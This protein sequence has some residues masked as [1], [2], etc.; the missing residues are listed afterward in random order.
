MVPDAN[1]DGMTWGV[2]PYTG[3][4]ISFAP[5][6]DLNVIIIQVGFMRS[7]PTDANIDGIRIQL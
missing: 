6:F 7:E 5:I 2:E 1:V 4:A 3:R